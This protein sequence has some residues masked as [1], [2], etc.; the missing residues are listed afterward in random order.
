M[1]WYFLIDTYIDAAW[2][3]SEYDS[4][5]DVVRPIVE[6]YGGVSGNRRKSA[7]VRWTPGL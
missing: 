5:I 6:S 2:G 1:A 3:R 4:Y 7:P